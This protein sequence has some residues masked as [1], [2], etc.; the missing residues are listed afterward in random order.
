MKPVIYIDHGQTNHFDKPLFSDRQLPYRTFALVSAE[1][2]KGWWVVAFDLAEAPERS[3]E[4]LFEILRE[5]PAPVAISVYKDGW[6]REFHTRTETAIARIENVLAL[7]DVDIPASFLTRR[8]TL[9]EA[10][11]FM[12]DVLQR[13]EAASHLLTLSDPAPNACYGIVAAGSASMLARVIGLDRKPDGTVDLGL[14]EPTDKQTTRRFNEVF[15]KGAPIFDTNLLRL[16]TPGQEPDWVQYDRIAW[17]YVNS[18][19]REL[20][21]SL[22]IETSRGFD[23][24]LGPDE[25]AAR[26]SNLTTFLSRLASRK[27]SD[28]MY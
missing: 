27:A 24:L 18:D 13:P 26:S 4:K 12:V 28:T 8:R 3:I 19:N 10:P 21:A 11:A 22:C 14:N 20:L 2:K 25:T 15:D 23:Y 9:T 6:F 5:R 7:R 16:E 17:R 1:L